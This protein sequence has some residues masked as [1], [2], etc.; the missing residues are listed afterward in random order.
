MLLVLLSIAEAALLFQ[1]YL[2]IQHAAREAARFA[3]TYQPPKGYTLDQVQELL[4]GA[5]LD[6]VFPDETEDEWHARRVG[7]IKDEAISQLQGLRIL[8]VETN[9]EE[10]PGPDDKQAGFVGVYVAGRP[11]DTQGFI[12]NHPGGPGLPVQVH[13][14]YRWLPIDPLIEA[15]IQAIA[16][17]GI[18]I[19]GQAEMINEGLQWSDWTPTPAPT[20][21]TA[22]VEGPTP[23][24]IGWT[25]PPTTPTATSTPTGTPTP[26]LTPTPEAPYILLAP[27]KEKWTEAGLVQ[28]RVEIHNH[29]PDGTYDVFWTDNCGNKTFLGF[30]MTT[31]GGTDMATLP[32]PSRVGRDFRYLCTPV[33]P[34]GTYT[35]TLS[36]I[37]AKVEVT[38]YVPVRVPDL[39]ISQIVLPET[40]SAGQA[41]TVGVVISSVGQGVVSD[42]FDVDLYVNPSHAPVLPGQ[43]GVTTAE[44]SAPKQWYSEPLPP[45]TSDELSY[46]VLP[47]K[48]GDYK[49]W[50]QVDTSDGVF[51]LDEGNNIYGPIE[52]S[53]FC[54]DKCDDFDPG[55]LD[56]KWALD[57]IGTGSG[58][59]S[60][61]VTAEGLLRMSGTGRDTDRADDGKSYM[62]DQGAHPGDWE[63]TVKVLDYPRG[64]EGSKAGLMARASGAAGARYAAIAIEEH[65]GSPALQVLVRDRDRREP[66]SL[67]GLNP[68]PGHLFDGTE[69][70]G[71]GVYLR[72]AR[73]GQTFTMGTS[74]DGDNW[75]T[76]GCMQYS[77]SEPGLPDKIL[78]A[79][80]FAPFAEG[81]PQQ[82][83][84]DRFR[85]CPNGSSGPPEVRAKPPLLEECG[86]VLLNTD[87]EPGGRLS[88]WIVGD[89]PQAVQSS[90]D[91]SADA[92]GQI[93]Q[94]HSMQF[95][96]DD[97]CPGDT[98][99]A[100]ATQE[101]ILPAFISTTQAVQ[102][103]M[104]ASLYGLVPPDPQGG[105]GRIEDKLWLDLADKSDAQLTQR[106][107]VIDGAQPARGTFHAFDRDLLSL[108]QVPDL[109]DYA[110]DTLRFRLYANSTDG[111]GASRFHVDQI[112]CDICAT[113]LAP[114]PEPDK[115][116][117][118]GGRILVILEGRP[119]AM[120]GIE[121]WAIQLPDGTTP[122]EGLGTW[123]TY[124]IQDSTYN[125][126][127]LNPGRYRIYAEVWVSGNLYTA[128]TTIQVEAGATVIDVNLNL[129]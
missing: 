104:R 17:D 16:P 128:A 52:L 24:P 14:Y 62:L 105:V 25:P 37:L 30:T 110:G 80:W 115:V 78:P 39:T 6:P 73:Q 126:F 59:A 121:V 10:P 12:W 3:V 7:L 1:T 15:L 40:V 48:P 94:G 27:A 31:T 38:L 123:S 42:T 72:I 83:L 51:E 95:Q 108:L 111:Q 99:Q 56:P 50:A 29:F 66:T 120:P 18:M 26:T 19:N 5:R 89:T 91:Y 122:P 41:I 87:F 47:S 93:V 113:V 57:P 124:S 71:E 33:E 86:N 2:A 23:T 74:M 20:L 96:L 101:F 103:E 22:T 107:V 77:F 67:C 100:W 82:A 54:S 34:G 117:R 11:D 70:N 35:A 119:T 53:L 90:T 106:V 97:T 69:S 109:R 98:C 43:P 8:D 84:Y 127:N 79:I 65:N 118:V 4:R 63:M 112:R 116:Y 129:L 125:M 88:P 76:T 55:P 44:G 92:N 60:H 46:V 114:E 58:N 102:I 75:Q 85:L 36:T 32:P 61:G 81:S 13:V 68:I 28:A 49:L 45:G 9:L 64:P 21:P